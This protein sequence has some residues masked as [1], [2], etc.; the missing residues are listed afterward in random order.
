MVFLSSAFTGSSPFTGSVAGGF[1]GV[2]PAGAATGVVSAGADGP[3]AAPQDSQNLTSG[4]TAAPHFGQAG[5]VSIFAPQ[6]SQNFIPGVTGLLHFWHFWGFSVMNTHLRDLALWNNPDCS[7]DRLRSVY[8]L[9]FLRFEKRE[10][11][12]F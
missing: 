2:A 9:C 7:S 3:T 6:D 11:S 1:S 4:A 12:R 8:A 10:V 5:K